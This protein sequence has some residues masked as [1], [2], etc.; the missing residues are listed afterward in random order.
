MNM[1]YLRNKSNAK[2]TQPIRTKTTATIGVRVTQRTKYSLS[3]SGVALHYK[4]KT[5]AI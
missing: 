4:N 5:F 1:Q 2:T 3:A